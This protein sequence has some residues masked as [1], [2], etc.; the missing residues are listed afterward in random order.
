MSDAT[1][2]RHLVLIGLMGSGKSVAGRRAAELLG[3]DFVDTDELVE[4]VAGA[5]VAQI[6]AAEGE[7]AFRAYERAAVARAAAASTPTVIACGGGAIID[8]ESCAQLRAAGT[9]VYLT[10]PVAELATRVG[11]DSRRP[12]LS[13]DPAE[14]LAQ[15][16]ALRGGSYER[17]S[18]VAVDVSGRSVDEVAQALC[19]LTRHAQL[20]L[21]TV[22]VRLADRSYTIEVGAGA[23]ARLTRAV[24]GHQRVAVVTQANIDALHGAALRY[25]LDAAGAAHHTFTMGD[26]ESAK[27]MTTVETL[28]REF[29]QWGLLRGDLVVAVGGGIVG[30]TAGFAAA[31]YHRGVGVVQVPT[32]L[33]AMVDSAIGGKTGVNLPEG[34]NLVGAFHQPR[35]VISDTAVLASLPD[36]E[37]RAGIGELIKYALLG[38]RALESLLQ[39]EREAITAREPAV[40][41]QL[42]AAAAAAKARVVEADEFERLGRRASLN[43]GHTLGHAVEI[44]GG[45]DLAHG[46]AVAVGLVFATALAAALERCSADRVGE[47][48][49]LVQSY[50]LPVAVPAGLTADTLLAL[51]RRDKKAHGGLTF[52]LDGPDGVGRVDD[53][54]AAALARAF[55][56]VGVA[57]LEEQP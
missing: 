21:V 44:A 32:T 7:P 30:D 19:D 53:P 38:D 33:L 3:W 14:S 49:A 42:V 4:A 47:V 22:P 56:A 34:K 9:V 17:A 29:A 31:S 41:A 5:T 10:A 55:A 20:D 26:G 12:L 48:R 28:C 52:V 36:R 6:F 24:G 1:G 25:A 50:G 57:A 23:L 18:D 11:R 35:A 40:V 39:A 16:L 43:L 13:D 8:P 2:R 46:E 45:H 51:M 15:L 37:Y 54:P 27:T